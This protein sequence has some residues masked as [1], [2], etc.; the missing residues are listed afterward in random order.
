MN[1][2]YAVKSYWSKE[3]PP[4]RPL[5]TNP[6]DLVGGQSQ[7]YLCHEKG[8][9]IS[10]NFHMTSVLFLFNHTGNK[11]DHP[12]ALLEWVVAPNEGGTPENPKVIFLL[13][14]FSS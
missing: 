11:D 1:N 4:F 6:I 5:E 13:L 7:M 14:T 12:L 3:F 10:H 8:N 2:Y 9:K